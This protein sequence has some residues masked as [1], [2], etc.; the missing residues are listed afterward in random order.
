MDRTGVEV[1]VRLTGD[2]EMGILNRRYRGKNRP[3]DVLAFAMQEGPPLP[4]PRR[5]R[6]LLGDM[7]VSVQTA[8]RQAARRGHSLEREMAILVIHGMLHLMGYDHERSAAAARKM[9]AKERGLRR[10]LEKTGPPRQRIP[11]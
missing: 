11:K 6:V 4:G 1:G 8:A 2:R 3:T 9:A 7:V 10:H 5:D